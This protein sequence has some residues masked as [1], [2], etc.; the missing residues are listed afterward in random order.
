MKRHRMLFLKNIRRKNVFLGKGLV[1]LKRFHNFPIL[2]DDDDDDD[3]D[4]DEN[5]D[6]DDDF[7]SLN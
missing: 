3:D 6:D 4:D 2:N 1:H 7:C 5:D